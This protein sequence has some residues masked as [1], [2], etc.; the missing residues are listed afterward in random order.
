MRRFIIDMT[1][2]MARETLMPFGEPDLLQA[3]E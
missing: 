2:D 1:E 3:A